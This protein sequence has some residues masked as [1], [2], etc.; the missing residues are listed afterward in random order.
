[1]V[2]S[3]RRFVERY[4]APEAWERLT[5]DARHELA[6]EVA[7]LPSE[8]E[9]ED[10]DAKRFDLLL[11]NLQ[12]ALMKAE[13]AFE[14]LSKQVQALAS[15]LEANANIPMIRDQL[16]LI[17]NIQTE[18]WWQ[19]VTV[20]MLDNARKRLR[21]LIKLID[22]KARKVIISDFEDQ[23]GEETTFDLPGFSA[24]DTFEKFRA[25]ARQF[26]LA[27]EDHIAVHKLRTNIPLTKTDLRELERILLESG[28]ATPDD[29]T[30]AKEA[31]QGLGLFVRSLVGMER[32]AAKNAMNAFLK[33]RTPTANQIQFLE[34]VVNHLTA[35][36]V[37]DAARLY[38]A[39]YTYI[40]PQG[41]EGVFKSPEIDELISILEEV[42]NRAIA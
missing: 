39:P 9:P 2:R 25:K 12:L 18:E 5:L 37:M 24:P 6:G 27:H 7:G 15:G 40:H 19:Y 16:D 13:P 4:A 33:G 34:E 14:R 36:G 31:S 20:E 23:M 42:K 3:K 29:V 28:T 21:L 38:E 17:Q 35:N 10:E 1:V 26:L 32:E 41:V 22:K 8:L 11:L 30:K